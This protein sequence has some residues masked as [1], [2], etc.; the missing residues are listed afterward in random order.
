[1]E[2][3]DAVERGVAGVEAT[4]GVIKNA[5]PTGLVRAATRRP[6]Q[7]PA[8]TGRKVYVLNDGS[9]IEVV[10]EMRSGNDIFLKTHDGMV[11]IKKGDIKQTLKQ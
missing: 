2:Q 10:L 4:L 6:S 1:M 9:R 8:A 11:N 5:L 3:M 7:A